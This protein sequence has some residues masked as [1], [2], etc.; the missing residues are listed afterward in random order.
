MYTQA[1]AV[2]PTLLGLR[3]RS[4]AAL[5]IA[6]GQRLVQVDYFMIFV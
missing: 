2:P 5:D 3:L 1:P 4:G 6:K